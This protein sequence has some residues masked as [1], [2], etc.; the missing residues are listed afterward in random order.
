MGYLLSVI[1]ISSLHTYNL[2][3]CLVSGSSCDDVHKASR[4]LQT[5]AKKSIRRDKKKEKEKQERKEKS[6]FAIHWQWLH[7]MYN[8]KTL[9]QYYFIFNHICWDIL[10]RAGSNKYMY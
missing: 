10:I 7:K 1:T 5:F 8:H 3:M 4:K 6:K 2:L 9:K